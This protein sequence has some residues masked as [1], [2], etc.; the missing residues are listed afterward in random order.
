MKSK[1]LII[2]EKILRLMAKAVLLRHKPKIIGIT[3]SVGKTSAKSAVF[4]VLSAKF[5]VRENQKNYNNEIGIPLTIIGVSSGEKNIFKWIWVFLKWI[6]VLVFPKYPEILI[7]ELGVDRPGDMTYFM[8]FI[9]PMIGIVTNISSSHIEYFGSVDNI[10]K[11]KGILIEKLG[12]DGFALLNGDDEKALATAKITK[13]QVITFGQGEKNIIGASGIVF[14]YQ[15]NIPQGL[16]FK[17]NYDGKNIPIRLRNI[18]AVHQ[19]NAALAAVGVGI[20]FKMNLVEIGSAL[21]TL[22]SPSGRMNLLEG[23]NGI[24]LIDDTYNASPVS[25]VAAIDVLSKLN[26]KRKIAILGDM[27]ELGDLSEGGHEEVGRK[28]FDCKID[29]FIAVGSRM[30]RA[31]EELVALGYPQES[32][33]HFDDPMQAIEKISNLFIEGDF[34]L[35]K[36]S[37][38]MR[39]EKIVEKLLKNSNESETLL[40]RQSSQWKKKIFLKP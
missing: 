32:I 13:A 15:D 33:M 40:C 10:A 19:V 24:F 36:G 18:L 27:L 16:S 37:Q 7:L 3:G 17:L 29:M 35:I 28:I 9:S 39:M 12:S 6:F 23:K 11:E 26:A 8:S 25:T 5:D 20:I 34:V 30:K 2:L 38:G 14:N 4:A 22:K 21:E 1:K 31:V